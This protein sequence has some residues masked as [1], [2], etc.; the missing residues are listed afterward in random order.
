MVTFGNLETLLYGGG[1]LR[2]LKI[3]FERTAHA[4]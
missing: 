3:G 2:N 4:C 1:F